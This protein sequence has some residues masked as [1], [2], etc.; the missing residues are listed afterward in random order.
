MPVDMLCCILSDDVPRTFG[1]ALKVCAVLCVCVHVGKNRVCINA[2]AGCGFCCDHHSIQKQQTAIAEFGVY[3]SPTTN[4]HALKTFNI[5]FLSTC[6]SMLYVHTEVIYRTTHIHLRTQTNS[7]LISVREL[8]QQ[9][10]HNNRQ[11]L[12]KCAIFR[13]NA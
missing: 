2:A 11:Q 5:F 7:Q 6:S 13:S 10:R 4:I 3:R 9:R 12:E 8:Q 1:W